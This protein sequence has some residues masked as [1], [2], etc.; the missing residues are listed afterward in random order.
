M[1]RVLGAYAARQLTPAQRKRVQR[2]LQACD[3]CRAALERESQLVGDLSVFMPQL[4]QPERAQ[5]AALWPTIRQRIAQRSSSS[6]QS[7]FPTY[8]M[9]VTV[10]LVICVLVGSALFDG[11]RRAVASPMAPSDVK[12]THTPIFTGEPTQVAARPVASLTAEVV[13]LDLPPPAS[14]VP[15]A[16]VR[17]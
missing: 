8:S 10:V 6:W 4:G 1:T 5:L 13:G 3:A 16:V 17:N 7:A 12:A 9:A 15:R 14:P 11:P 2:H